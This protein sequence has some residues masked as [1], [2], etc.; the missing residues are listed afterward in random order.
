MKKLF[1][2]DFSSTHYGFIGATIKNLRRKRIDMSAHEDIRMLSRLLACLI[3]VTALFLTAGESA[4]SDSTSAT[5]TQ[6]AAA[7]ANSCRWVEKA[8]DWVRSPIQMDIHAGYRIFAFYSDG[9]IG[10]RVR[11]EFPYAAFMSFTIYDNA[12]LYA[13]LTDY[14]IEADPGSI[15]PFHSNELI[16]APNRAYTVTVL[17]HNARPDSMANPI[18]M[19][20]L[21]N[22][23]NP[24]SLVLVQRI[25]L[26]EPQDQDRFG[27]V[28][29]PT[30][31]P[32]QVRTSA[33][34]ACPSGD[35]TAIFDQFG[36]F[37]GNFSQSPLPRNGKIEFYRA[38][39][40][41]VPFADG[42]SPLTKHDCTSYLMATV[43]PDKLAVI[44]LPALP[45]FFDNAHI[46][47]T[48]LFEEPEVHYLSMGSY[49]ASRLY[50]SDNE[51]V[52]GPDLKT[53]PDGS[54]VFIAIPIRLPDRLKK[55]VAKKAEKLGY[56]VMPLAEYGP[57]IP[58]AVNGPKINPFLIYRNKVPREGFV[59]SILNVPCF[60]GSDFS[61]ASSD[62]A[63]SP[64]NMDSY[65]P[66]G[67]ECSL[68]DFLYGN[69]GQY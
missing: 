38:P 41:L 37:G 31:E 47:D 45:T 10:Y 18:F 69:C 12:F 11:G 27:G 39:A 1:L 48:T 50:A 55:E 36:S 35:F 22:G 19:P 4:S 33:P 53:L 26:G 6:Y 3:F 30:I 8:P 13:A 63:A 29:A 68:S 21:P 20:P 32:F 62:Y 25:Y 61:E 14:E 23:S 51:N 66:I 15:N 60:Q 9:T 59:G 56:N 44:H 7:D 42:S 52:A 57:L 28:D 54:A 64:V 2:T 17:P 16:N 34:A 65:A 67:I 5:N 24:T 43:F 46:T 49:G 58:L 40:S